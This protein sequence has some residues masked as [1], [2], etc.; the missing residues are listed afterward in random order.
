MPSIEDLRPQKFKVTIRGV[1]LNCSP[2]RLSHAL[3]V[4]K[5]GDVF[6]S[7]KEATK[8][9][10]IQ[11]QKDMDEVINELIP[12]L[13]GVEL[14]MTDTIDLITQMTS[15]TQPEDNQYLNKAGVKFDAEKKT[16]VTTGL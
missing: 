6:Q 1:D 15:N 12:E 11:A 7:P 3:I 4:A 13:E 9:S 5:I 10:I 8:E 16:K 2:L 14:N